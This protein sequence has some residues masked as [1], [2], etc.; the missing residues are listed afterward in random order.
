MTRGSPQ[1]IGIFPD[2]VLAAMSTMSSNEKLV[3]AVGFLRQLTTGEAPRL[4]RL[5]RE[6]D[7]KNKAFEAAVQGVVGLGVA[8]INGPCL[9]NLIAKK[10][11]KN[12][13]KFSEKQRTNRSKNSGENQIKSMADAEPEGDQNKTKRPPPKPKPLSKIDTEETNTEPNLIN[14]E[15]VNSAASGAARSPSSKPKTRAT[16]PLPAGFELTDQLREFASQ[17]GYGQPAIDEMFEKFRAYHADK[18]TLSADWAASWQSWVLRQ[19]DFN[20]RNAPA[21]E[22]V[23]ADE[24][25]WRS[26]ANGW[27]QRGFWMA[28]WGPKPGEPNSEIP[29]P[30]RHLFDGAAARQQRNQTARGDAA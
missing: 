13:Q 10:Q 29:E 6:C 27:H 5:Q 19:S 23:S 7:L 8:S 22:S 3:C 25:R 9:E 16:G 1:W 18:G 24:S 11:Q 2:D 26:I 28:P 20:G 17:R 15:S 4:D 14:R 12:S 30:Y 21:P